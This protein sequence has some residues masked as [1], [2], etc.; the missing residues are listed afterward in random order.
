MEGE[1]K[2]MTRIVAIFAYWLGLDALFYWLNRRRKRIIA[3][4]NVLPD[5]MFREGVANGVSNRLS[6]FKKIVEMCK[7]RFPIDTAMF[8]A[9][10]LTITF[11][12]GYHNQYEYAF[13]TLRELGVGAYVFVSGNTKNGALTID[14]LLHW[15]SEAPIE[16]IPNGDRAAYWEYEIWPKFLKDSKTKGEEVLRELDSIYPY[17]KV[18]A[19]LPEDYKRE[20]LTGISEEEFKE[21]R[22]NGWQIGWH[23][24]SHYPLAKLSESQVRDEL[25]SPK[26]FRSTCLSYPYG[27]PCEV[28]EKAIEIS[29]EFGY[30]CAVANTNEAVHGRYFL[31][32]MALS[33]D[34]Y[35]LHFELSGCK[36]FLKTRKLLKRV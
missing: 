31:P 27:N 15:V 26:E 25:V 19:S 21:M 33:S 2:D 32:R 24:K 12:D 35:L 11:D 5:E 9:R 34:K 1:R 14:K 22:A 4:H 6:D 30:P 13:K 29:K 36:Y 10:S 8:N 7:R 23:T 18:L 17:E 20:R 28:G 16:Y 3:F